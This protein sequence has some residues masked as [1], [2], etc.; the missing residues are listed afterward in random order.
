MAASCLRPGTTSRALRAFLFLISACLLHH[1]A[2]P[3]AA[4]APLFGRVLDAT[5]Q[6]IAG[7]RVIVDGPL[8]ARVVETDAAGRFEIAD[9]PDAAYRVLLDAD[10]FAATPRTIRVASRE[11]VT[12]SITAQIAPLTEAVVVS[13]A[14]VPRPR[15]ESP[16]AIDVVGRQEIEARQLESVADVLRTAPGFAVSRNGGRGALTS[17]FPRGGE[18]DYTLVLVD[19]MRVNTFGETWLFPTVVGASGAVGV[20]LGLCLVAS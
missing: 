9:L 8:G 10:G 19:G 7:A 17:V 13:A 16:V 14:A 20:V 3:P 2:A 1:A 15:S 5:G 12:L 6:P 11:P 18:S 4:A